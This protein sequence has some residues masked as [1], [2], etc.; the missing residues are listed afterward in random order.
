M[1]MPKRTVGQRG[2]HA[3]MRQAL[4]VQVRV[5]D[6]QRDNQS[7]IGRRPAVDGTQRTEVGAAVDQ[8]F[9]PLGHRD[10]FGHVRH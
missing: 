10:R 3:A 4:H 6:A 5:V 8:R 9:V 1:L 7:T 2:Q